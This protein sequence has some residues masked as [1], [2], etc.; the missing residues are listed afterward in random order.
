[1]NVN[2]LTVS[3]LKMF[4]MDGKFWS[5]KKEDVLRIKEWTI[6]KYTWNIAW[7]KERDWKQI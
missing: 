4:E 2:M 7:D 5:L 6:D 1:M 3:L